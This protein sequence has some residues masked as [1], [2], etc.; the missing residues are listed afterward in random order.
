MVLSAL[1]LLI[2]SGACLLVEGQTGLAPKKFLTIP[3]GQV[4]PAGWLMDQLVVQTNGLAGHEHEFYNYVSNTDWV[5]GTSAYSNLEEAGSYWFNAMVPNSFLVN[6]TVIQQKTL[7]FL[8]YVLTH[9]DSTGWLGPE[10]NTTKPR[11]LWG[12]YPFFFGAIQLTEVHPELTDRVV[13]ALHKFVALANTMLKNNGEGV[14][15][16][17][18]TRWEDFVISLQWLY[19]YHPN[20]NEALLIDTMQ[21][22][23]WTGVPWEKVFSEQYFPQTAVEHTPNPFNLPLTWHGV[24]M[25]EGLKALPS[26]YRFTHNQTDLDVASKGWDLLFQYH[27]RPSG[28]YAADE[29][30]AGLEAVRGTEL[31]LVVETMFSGSYLYQV[32]GDPKFADRVERITY[33]ALPATL[34]GNMWSRQYL[35]QQNQVASK[36]MNPNPFPNDGAYSNVFGLQP[37]YPCCTVNFPQGL[38]KFISNA[39]LTTPDQKSLVHLYLG[40]FSTSTTLASGNKVTVNV[41]TLYPFSDTLTTTITATSAFTYYVRIPSWVSGGTIAIN[42]GQATA[43]R[44][45]NGLHAVSVPAGTTKFTLNLPATIT[46]ESRPHGSIAVH[47]GVFNFAFDIPRSQTVLTKNAQ[48][49]LA[50]D[51]EFDATA[52]WQFAIDPKTLQFHT[53]SPSSLPSPVFDSGK[54]PLSITVTACPINWATAGDTF[55]ASPPTSPVSCTGSNT[56]LTLTPFGTTKL[57]ISEFPVRA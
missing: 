48:Q 41:D 42:G 1:R 56:T 23:K 30:L 25:A 57:R 27:G 35:Q 28:I 13:T 3:L 44:P 6:N 8:N 16:W 11:Y 21:R 43:V 31:C 46:T 17:T 18:Q 54:S 20:G 49:P 2:L 36:N 24:N 47:R 4:K 14:E 40:P 45:T 10:V 15:A 9:Q 7:D 19:D 22:L 32:I 5:G 26:T 33:N 29:Y 37:N 38:P 34:T 55:A 12:R 52:P 51:L 39:F 53:T 50:V